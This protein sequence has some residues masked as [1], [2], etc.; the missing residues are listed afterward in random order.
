MADPLG[1]CDLI[2]GPSASE[3]Q[4]AL[5]PTPLQRLLWS[6]GDRALRKSTRRATPGQA[7]RPSKG[8]GALGNAQRL[9]YPFVSTVLDLLFNPELRPIASTNRRNAS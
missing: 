2:R 9:L 4:A 6:S 5:T 7:R 1:Q 8:M 3:T